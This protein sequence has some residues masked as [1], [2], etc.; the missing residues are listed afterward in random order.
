MEHSAQ[1]ALVPVSQA[2]IQ[3]RRTQLGMN[4]IVDSCGL[5]L[6][7][8]YEDFLA[9]RSSKRSVSV[10]FTGEKCDTAART[11]GRNCRVAYAV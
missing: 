1:A 6:M 9:W 5:P 10:D 7:F 11:Y 4:A 2:L 8:L 3:E